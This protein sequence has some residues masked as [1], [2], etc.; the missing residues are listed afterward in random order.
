MVLLHPSPSQ[1]VDCKLIWSDEFNGSVIDYSNWTHQVFPGVDSGNNELQY[2]TARPENSR[3]E[4]GFLII[5][6]HEENY[7]NHNYTSARLHSTG[8]RDFLYGR[9]EARIKIP[10]GQ[11]YW[12]AFW[13]LPTDWEYG[14]W[15]RSGEIDIMESV[16]QADF[17]SGAVHFGG[18]WPE[19]VYHSLAYVGPDPQNPLDFSL[20]F[21]LYSI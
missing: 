12:P 16:N 3:V 5:E 19:H 11:G 21:H 9:I 8:K 2:Y 1:A 6:A 13:M 20:D 10:K 4:N 7:A 15:P 18:N 17:V 14:G